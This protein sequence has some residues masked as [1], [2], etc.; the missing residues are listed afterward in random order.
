MHTGANLLSVI[1]LR[2]SYYDT[3]CGGWFS[4][5]CPIASCA[6]TH[7]LTSLQ[8][9]GGVSRARL[10]AK[11]KSLKESERRVREA[12]AKLT[13]EDLTGPD[14]TVSGGSCSGGGGG[15]ADLPEASSFD[16]AVRQGASSAAITTAAAAA[17]GGGVTGWEDTDDAR[18]NDM[19]V[20][21]LFT[22]MVNFR[23]PR[24]IHARLLCYCLYFFCWIVGHH[25]SVPR[26]LCACFPSLQTRTRTNYLIQAP[27]NQRNH[28]KL[29]L[30]VPAI[31]IPP[32]PPPKRHVFRYRTFLV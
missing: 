16:P 3:S 30:E 18:G 12:A 19:E 6:C 28:T 15:S 7:V 8:R 1:L 2:Y 20:G 5:T 25:N 10:K 21:K 22:C 29:S 9:A 14:G 17:A 23:S 4:R 26:L 13:G 24:H 11:R 32:A 31:P 27:H